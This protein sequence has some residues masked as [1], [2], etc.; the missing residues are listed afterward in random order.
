MDILGPWPSDGDKEVYVFFLLFVGFLGLPRS[1]PNGLGG[2]Q[3]M[4]LHK[5]DGVGPTCPCA[6]F[7]DGKV[8]AQGGN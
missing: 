8:K 6:P 7:R 2:Y 1:C 4:D 3:L 5:T